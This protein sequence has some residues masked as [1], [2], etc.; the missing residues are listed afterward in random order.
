MP[1][2]VIYC[3]V[4]TKEQT[5]NFSLPEQER[6]C[7]DYCSRNGYHVSRVFIERGESAKTADRTE[8][9]KLLAFSTQ[10]GAKIDY[11]VVHKV[12]RLSRDV[13]DFY[14]IQATLGRAGVMIRSVDQA[15]DETPNGK[16]MSGMHA[17][18]AEYENNL[19]A[20]RTVTGMKAALRQ[21]RWTH[22]P[23]LGYRKPPDPGGPSLEPDADQGS[24]V[25]TAFEKMASGQYTQ[26]DVLRQVTALGLKSKRS[27]RALTPQSFNRTLRNPIYKGW[28]E[29]SLTEPVRGDFDPLVSEEVFDRVQAELAGRHSNR[30]RRYSRDNPL[31]PL[32]GFVRCGN[33]RKPLRGSR[34][35]G[36]ERRYGYYH[37]SNRGDV[38]T[39]REQ[40]EQ[41]FYCLLDALRVDEGVLPLFR[42]VVEDVWKDSQAEVQATK[43]RLDSRMR[44]IERRKDDLVEAAVHQKLIDAATY[45]V[46]SDKLEAQRLELMVELESLQE[47]LDIRPIMEFAE[48]L[49]VDPAGFWEAADPGQKRRFQELIYPSGLEFD[50]E[51]FRIAVTTPVFSYLQQIQ[52]AEERMVT[53]AGIEPALPA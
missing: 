39:R 53:P 21:G 38:R 20:E 43:K 37:C 46:Q 33:C 50:G 29:T 18:M 5:Q 40:L 4:S 1:N 7:R 8:L 36:R 28:I 25:A 17:L 10:K 13:A 27:G 15:I 35:K 30:A 52:E 26:T 6:R 24:L 34:S 31:F 3:R 16:L 19:R 48:Q 47:K 22:Q 9:K 23:P 49:M 12:D 2:A 41:R 32:K 45:R 11:L 42:V 44:A 51:D 14:A